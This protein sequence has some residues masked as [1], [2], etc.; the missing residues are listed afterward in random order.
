MFSIQIL[1]KFSKLFIESSTKKDCKAD[2]SSCACSTSTTTINN[3]D[4]DDDD[5]DDDKKEQNF[6]DVVDDL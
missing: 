1:Q 3:H 5:D 4:N 2:K 6:E